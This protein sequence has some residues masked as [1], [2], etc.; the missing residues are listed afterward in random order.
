MKATVITAAATKITVM[1]PKIFIHRCQIHNVDP[2]MAIQRYV[3]TYPFMVIFPSIVSA[4]KSG[5]PRSG[6]FIR[7]E[8]KIQKRRNSRKKL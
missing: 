3:R 4:S 8:S 7:K 1:V 5:P 2:R 6:D